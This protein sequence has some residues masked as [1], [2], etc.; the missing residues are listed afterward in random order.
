MT[1]NDERKLRVLQHAEQTGQVA[2]TG[3]YFGIG[4]GKP[5]RSGG[6]ILQFKR[7]AAMDHCLRLF[8]GESHLAKSLAGGCWLS[9]FLQPH[10]TM[11]ASAH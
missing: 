9:S 5:G 1:K 11:H 10:W 4:R 2:K 3:R 8:I 6:C 7:P